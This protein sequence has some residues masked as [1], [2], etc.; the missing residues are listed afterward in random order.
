MEIGM[1]VKHAKSGKDMGVI[2]R[3]KTT[4]TNN[5]T[6]TIVEGRYHGGEPWIATPFELSKKE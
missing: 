2:E 4:R 5:V 3:I 6:W 1:R